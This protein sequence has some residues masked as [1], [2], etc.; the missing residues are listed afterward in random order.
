MGSINSLKGSL[1]EFSLA[2]I[3][4]LVSMGAKSGCLSLGNGGSGEK[5]CLYFE[6]GY[7]IHACINGT[8]GERAARELLNLSDCT[9]E[10]VPDRQ[11][12]KKTVMVS[13]CEL[14]MKV[15]QMADEEAFQEQGG[16]LVL[17]IEGSFEPDMEGVREELV[18]LVRNCLGRRAGPPVE[19]LEVADPT[20]EGF[21]EVCDRI[22]SYVALFVGKEVS[23][24]LDRR[25]RAVVVDL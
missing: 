4:Q 24:T 3:V 17:E 16:Q 22:R 10:F 7:V 1:G 25:M 13:G 18:S 19:A 6:Y 11:P 15:A 21:L 23:V 20:M 2:D 5:G 8:E 9:F 14:L 12:D